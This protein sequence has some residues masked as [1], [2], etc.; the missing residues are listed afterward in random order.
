LALGVQSW[1]LNAFSLILTWDILIK[2]ISMS[3]YNFGG[4]LKRG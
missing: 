1:G 4:M 2:F 3:S